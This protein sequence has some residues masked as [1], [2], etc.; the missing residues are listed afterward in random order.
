MAVQIAISDAEL[1]RTVNKL[2]ALRGA[3][4]KR[5]FQSALRPGAKIIRDAAKANV[6][7]SDEPH[8]GRN[9][10]VYTPRNLHN[11]IVV[12]SLR[13]S[14][15]LFVGV[16]TKSAAT[17]SVFGNDTTGGDADGY[18]AHWV[19]F[20]TQNV[21]GST[22]PGFGFMRKAVAAKKEEAIAAI[23]KASEAL[24]SKTVKKISN[25]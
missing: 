25:Q 13:R 24:I 21:D 8:K 4:T 2:R 23:V 22:R 18:Y 3:L 9:G 17:A 14:D 12:K 11:S 7:I 15:A 20:N 16:K 1:K 6:P 10:K 19:E 5:Q